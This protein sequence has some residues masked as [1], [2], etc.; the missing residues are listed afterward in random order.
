MNLNTARTWI[1]AVGEKRLWI[2]SWTQPEHPDVLLLKAVCIDVDKS[3]HW[4]R[5]VEGFSKYLLPKTYYLHWVK[6]SPMLART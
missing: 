5:A 2:G 3:F 1:A 6:V 4:Q